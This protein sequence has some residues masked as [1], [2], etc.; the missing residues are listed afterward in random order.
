MSFQ[1]AVRTC[2]GKY[3][4]FTGR[5]RR[6]EYWWFVVFTAV[7]TTIASVVDAIVGTKFGNFGLFQVLATLALLLPELAVGARRLH[8]VGRSGWMLLLLIIPVIGALILV[9]AFFIRDSEPDNDYGPSPKR[10]VEPAPR[11]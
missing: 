11:G 5:A 8:D 1:D 3:A 2:L 10:A 7:V 9:V 6:S 4:D